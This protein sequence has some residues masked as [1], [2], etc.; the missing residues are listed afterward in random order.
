M[1]FKSFLRSFDLRWFLDLWADAARNRRRCRAFGNHKARPRPCL[2][3]MLEDRVVPAST[4]NV[5]LATD[6]GS[7]ASGQKDTTDPTGL[8]GDIRY[9]ILQAD[10][11]INAGSTIVFSNT[12]A[13]DTIPLVRGELQIA[14]D[15]TIT[16]LGANSITINANGIS[17]IFDITS[18]SATVTITGL[19]VTGGNG[20]PANTGFAGNQ[21]GDIFNSSLQLTLNGDVITNGRAAGGSTGGNNSALGGGIFNAVGSSLTIGNSTITGNV[22]Q[23]V[24]G[25]LGAGGG[26]YIQGNSTVTLQAGVVIVS[27]QALGGAGQGLS[28]GG[29]VA[30]LGTL[31]VMGD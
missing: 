31:N 28:E 4:Y 3:E 2:V 7:F 29:G 21:G 10:Q 14:Q 30:N 24:V 5:T 27:N 11:P 9:C 17:R 19:T 22:A 12:L 16:G 15:M 25:G 13:G 20:N 6:N 1:K 26:I 8:S 23:G 18:E